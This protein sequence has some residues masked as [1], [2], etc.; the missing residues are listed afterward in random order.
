LSGAHAVRFL[1]PDFLY[2]H[3]EL[4]RKIF[5][6]A[7]SSDSFF[8]D[9]LDHSARVFL[10]SLPALERLVAQARERGIPLEPLA[11]RGLRVDGPDEPPDSAERLLAMSAE[12]LPRLLRL[13]LDRS[14]GRPYNDHLVVQVGG[15]LDAAQAGWLWEQLPAIR[16]NALEQ[17]QEAVERIGR[18]NPRPFQAGFST[19]RP[20]AR[21]SLWVGCTAEIRPQNEPRFLAQADA[22]AD[23]IFPPLEAAFADPDRIKRL[24]TGNAGRLIA[25][26]KKLGRPPGR[27]DHS[28]F[29]PWG[30]LS[31]S[32]GMRSAA[33]AG[34]LEARL[35]FTVRGTWRAKPDDPGLTGSLS[36]Y[37]QR[38]C[39]PSAERDREVDELFRRAAASRAS[40]SERM[41]P[42]E[43]LAKDPA[44][45]SVGGQRVID[46]LARL[47]LGT[48][49]DSG[50]MRQAAIE[51]LRWIEAPERDRVYLAL[52]AARPPKDVTCVI[53]QSLGERPSE[54]GVDALLALWRDPATAEGS[55]SWANDGLRNAASHCVRGQSKLKARVE[56]ELKR[57][58]RD[59][60]L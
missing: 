16:F 57:G 31:D 37:L 1:E 47:A 22:L 23:E 21:F 3:E 20:G 54:V 46:T 6:D 53:A 25:L 51:T 7:A 49:E 33:D 9:M 58:S 34:L 18:A 13:P 8:S 50:G 11:L 45:R 36:S 2:E 27:Q 56:R 44:L 32:L 42:L 48:D 59:T 30:P 26:Q 39:I 60:R 5:R 40:R 55:R 41:D 28:L 17:D 29:N 24:V 15:A 43:R 4:T 14:P 52:L 38:L 35:L 12:P 19:I 10:A